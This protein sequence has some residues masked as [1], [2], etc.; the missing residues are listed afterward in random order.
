MSAAGDNVVEVL[1]ARLY[2]ICTDSPPRGIPNAFYFNVD[3][4]LRYAPFFADFG[5]VCIARVCWFATELA[6]VLQAA[7]NSGSVVYHQTATAAHARANSAFIAG[8][9]MIAQLG[10]G[11]EETARR[12]EAVVPPFAPFRDASCGPCSHACTLRHCFRGFEHALRA[13]LIDPPA[14]DAR[15]YEFLEKAQNGDL[16]WIVPGKLLAL[17]TPGE[18][19]S[20]RCSLDL[21]GYIE[22]FKR[23]GVGLVIQLNRSSYDTQ[24]FA[25]AGVAHLDLSFPDGSTPSADI[26]NRFLDAVEGARGAVAVH[27]KAGLGR[28]GTLIAVYLM[29]HYRFCGS[30][31]IAFLRIMRPGSILGPQQHFLV[32]NQRLFWRLY[33]PLFRAATPEFAAFVQR[34]HD[35]DDC[36]AAP[37]PFDALPP[38]EQRGQGE[39][40]LRAK[41]LAAQ[42]L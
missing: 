30:D 25:A 31:A 15:Q 1:P 17:S 28:T 42:T 24:A 19:G 37:A 26:I 12:F 41:G 11:W 14:F 9:F 34:L 20:A 8:C 36:A 16:T 40:L 22:L 38:A 32:H 39:R 35:T 6:R 21:P 4:E 10:L 13:G 23:L 7:G 27:C 2:W 29:K 5:P 18:R 33:S 3:A